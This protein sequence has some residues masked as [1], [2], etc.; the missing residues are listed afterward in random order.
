MFLFKDMG[1]NEK[2][3]EKRAQ[4][5]RGFERERFLCE[6]RVRVRSKIKRENEREEISSTT[7]INREEKSSAMKTQAKGYFGRE[8]VSSEKRTGARQ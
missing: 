5:G 7:M 1:T 8:E 2:T 4:L 6:Q 3:S